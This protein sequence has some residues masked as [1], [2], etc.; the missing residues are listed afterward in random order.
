MCVDIVVVNW[1]AANLLKECIGSLIQYRSSLVSRIVVVDNGSTDGS[2]RFLDQ[3]ENVVLI[4]ANE[5]LGFA[6]ACNLGASYCKSEFILFLNPDAKI[7]S[8]TLYNV[9]NYMCKPEN[10]KVGI[11]GVQL[12]DEYGRL[13]R[14]SSRFP[15][16]KGFMAHSLGITKIFPGLGDAMSEWDHK[17]TR[18]VD[19]VIGAFFFVRR[20]VFLELDGFDEQFFVYFEE[21]DFA[22]RANKIGWISVYLSNVKA[23]HVGG[24]VSDQV[25]AK[26]LFYSR[27]SRILYAYKHFDR[28]SILITLISTLLFEPVVRTIAAIGK[29][30]YAQI[31]ENLYAYRML[32]HWFYVNKF[33]EKK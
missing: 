25:K 24:G 18:I 12:Y 6:K 27:R 31:K 10:A 1:N 11:C 21:V 7:Y 13:A 16:V 33:G 5:N 30:S 19:Q 8:D 14:S 9:K 28:I 2:E 29:R 3:Q 20:K 17:N 4:R 26:R 32:Y 22:Y 15:S 23:F